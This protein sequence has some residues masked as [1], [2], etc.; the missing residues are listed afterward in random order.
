MKTFTTAFA[1][2]SLPWN[3]NW[4]N[5]QEVENT[6][7]AANRTIN[8]TEISVNNYMIYSIGVSI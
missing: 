7:T 3:Q 1:S 6:I 8:N 2:V 5:W 4:S